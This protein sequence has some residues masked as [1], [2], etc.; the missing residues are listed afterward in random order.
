MARAYLI[1][2]TDLRRTQTTRLIGRWSQSGEVRPLLARRPSSPRR[3][4]PCDVALLAPC[5]R[6]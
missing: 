4:R 5:N 6:T 3:Y 1:K 2:L